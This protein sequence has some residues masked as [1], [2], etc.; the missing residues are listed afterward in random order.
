M[1]THVARAA[2]HRPEMNSSGHGAG[3][4]RQSQRG[5]GGV[6]LP[7]GIRA[8]LYGVGALLWLS[9]AVWLVLH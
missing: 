5:A 7:R 6:T 9:G 2:L 8:T 3:E 1:S 4:L